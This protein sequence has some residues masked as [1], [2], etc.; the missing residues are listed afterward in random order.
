MKECLYQSKSHASKKKRKSPHQPL[1]GPPSALV[2]MKCFGVFFQQSS[3]N[4]VLVL[5][6]VD[7]SILRSIRSRILCTT[8]IRSRFVPGFEKTLSCS[9]QNAAR[10]TSRWPSTSQCPPPD[11][12]PFFQSVWFDTTE[13]PTEWQPG[14]RRALGTWTQ[15]R[16][17]AHVVLVRCCVNSW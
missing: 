12:T 8:K 15:A 9:F 10:S 6:L 13:T 1:A 2:K 3:S 5:L 7:F 16:A 17:K 14:G 11:S 4:P